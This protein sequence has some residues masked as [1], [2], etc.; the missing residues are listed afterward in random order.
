MHE[1][2]TA[3]HGWAN[4]PTGAICSIAGQLN[5]D[6][7]A[8]G[9]SDG[10]SLAVAETRQNATKALLLKRS[11]VMV[12]LVGG[13][14]TLDELLEILELKKHRVHD[15]PVI[16]LNAEGFYSGLQQQMETMDQLDFLP[17]P[18]NELV[19]FV[20]SAAEALSVINELQTTT[21]LAE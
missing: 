16:V 11:D 6:I 20:P 5:A 10:D 3:G 17:M 8:I 13:I 7:A 14:G 21:S 9:T 18:L 15:K 4:S 19:S 1:P 12:A 2:K